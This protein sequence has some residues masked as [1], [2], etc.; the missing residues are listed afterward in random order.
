[1]STISRITRRA[2]AAG[3]VLGLA[4]VSA[5]PALAED[6]I[7]YS[8]VDFGGTVAKAFEA[9]TGIKVNLV[10]PGGTGELLGKIAAEGN[11]PQFDLVWVDGSA[12]LERMLGDKVLQPVPDALFA[13]ADYTAIGKKL[14][15]ASHA[16]LPTSVSTT[17]IT[18]NTKK[19]PADKLPKSFADLAT[20]EFIGFVGAKDPNLSGPS[21]QFI[22]GLFQVMGEEKGKDYLK[23][24][25][26]NKKM[27]GLASGGPLNKAL[28]TGDAKVGFSQDSSTYA[29]IDKG[30]P[31]AVIYPSEGVVAL[32]AGIGMSAKTA[33]AAA[34]A[35]FIEFAVGKDG[36]TAMQDGDDTDY[37]LAPIING[38]PAKK[39]RVTGVNY[40]Y[41]DGVVAGAKEAEWKKW[42]KD[43]FVP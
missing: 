8:A 1:M 40:V 2:L 4:G 7:I 35:K 42:Y 6:L 37:Y 14:V 17:S 27:S 33:N 11:N 34:A 39:G 18:V 22:A 36:Q 15:P 41:L 13:K 12:I 28:L 24:V 32:P 23:K 25:L 31:L 10:E 21:F 43:N 29:K 26:A 19:V 16:F 30:E 5:A 38:I 3:L 9:K 20:P